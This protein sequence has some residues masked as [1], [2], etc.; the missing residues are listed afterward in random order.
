MTDRAEYERTV[1]TEFANMFRQ[2]RPGISDQD[3]GNEFE[4]ARIFFTALELFRADLTKATALTTLRKDTL[5]DLAAAI[6]DTAPGMTSWEED[7]NNK[8]R[9]YD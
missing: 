2:R 5:I 4:A 3:V 8:R 1:I 6:D 9:G 7:L